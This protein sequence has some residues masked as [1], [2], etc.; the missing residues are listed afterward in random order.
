MNFSENGNKWFSFVSEALFSRKKFFKETV[1]LVTKRFTEFRCGSTIP[2]YAVR[3]RQPIKVSI[4]EKFRNDVWATTEIS[5]N[6]KA[7]G[8]SRVSLVSILK[9]YLGMGKQFVREVPR[10][11]IK[12]SIPMITLENRFALFSLITDEFFATSIFI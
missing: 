1:F 8:K 5:H 12:Q 3:S 2:S 10:H 11:N 6:L 7:L 9:D 4:L